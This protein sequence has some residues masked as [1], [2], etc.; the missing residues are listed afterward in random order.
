MTPPHEQTSRHPQ[1]SMVPVE[2]SNIHSVGYHPASSTMWVI[3]KDGGHY[4]Y[5]G[6]KPKVHADFMASKSKGKFFHTQIRGKYQ[7]S[8]LK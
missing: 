5:N 1:V 4:V 6:V 7:H 8:K 3:F 2:S